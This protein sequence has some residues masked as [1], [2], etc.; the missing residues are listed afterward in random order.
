MV[1]AEARAHDDGRICSESEDLF[2]EL[3]ARHFGHG[4]VGND[5]IESGWVFFQGRKGLPAVHPGCHLVAEFH[6]GEP[7]VRYSAIRYFL[8]FL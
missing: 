6:A 3:D 1:F 4:L 7:K 5:K 8:I 2:R